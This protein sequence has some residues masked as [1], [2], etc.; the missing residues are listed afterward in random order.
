MKNSN[1]GERIRAVR[2]SLSRAA[3]GKRIGIT[4]GS[5]R[6]YED[7]AAQPNAEV[8]AKIC[9]RCDVSTDWLLLGIGPMSACRVESSLP[10][11]MAEN[12]PANADADLST[13]PVADR[14][15]AC[16]RCDE[17]WAELRKEM[18]AFRKTNEQLIRMD[19]ANETMRMRNVTLEEEIR[20]LR[21]RILSL[22]RENVRLLAT[23]NAEG[24]PKK[25]SGHVDSMTLVSAPPRLQEHSDRFPGDVFSGEQ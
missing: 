23:R 20:A 24:K 21:D 17:L 18:E 10:A 11:V 1:L 15:G 6:N 4:S 8:L 25:R 19:L 22:E 12:N 3:F 2:G 9:E 13:V 14:T 5:L 7:G 16:A